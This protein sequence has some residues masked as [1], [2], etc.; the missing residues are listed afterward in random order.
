MI[1]V[2]ASLQT[3]RIFGDAEKEITLINECLGLSV[4]KKK[5]PASFNQH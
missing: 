4:M 1:H 3:Q 5:W 2:P